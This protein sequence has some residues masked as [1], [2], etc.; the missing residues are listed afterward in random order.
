[1]INNWAG[2]ESFLEGSFSKPCFRVSSKSQHRLCQEW[3]SVDDTVEI[4]KA[5]EKMINIRN[6]WVNIA[7]EACGKYPRASWQNY[8]L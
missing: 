5:L 2:Q 4:D 3:L 6:A 7:Q 8:V 1:M